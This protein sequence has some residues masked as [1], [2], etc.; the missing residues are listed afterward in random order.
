MKTFRNE[1][2]IIIIAFRDYIASDETRKQVTDTPGYTGE[3]IVCLDCDF[4]CL[5]SQASCR[6][7]KVKKK[8]VLKWFEWTICCGRKNPFLLKKLR[9]WIFISCEHWRKYIYIYWWLQKR[10]AKVLRLVCCKQF[11]FTLDE[12]RG[13]VRF[14][15]SLSHCPS[16]SD[17][18]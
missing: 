4:V 12:I 8:K 15:P 18:N 7:G 10:A 13:R 6:R 17:F 1:S 14:I 16:S 11:K 2:T 9:K 3:V 5:Y